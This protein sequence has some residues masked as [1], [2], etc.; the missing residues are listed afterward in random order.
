MLINDFNIAIDNWIMAVKNYRL[1]QLRLQPEENSWSIGQICV[2]LL[3]DTNWFLEQIK[4][5]L[6]NDNR[7]DETV[8]SFANKMFEA[9]SFP[10]EKLTNPSN[11]NM[12]Q[13]TNKE[14]LLQ[15][16]ISLK[17]EMNAVVPQ[18]ENTISDGKTKHPGF[19]YF[20]ATEWLQFATMHLNHH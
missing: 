13:P 2:H 10:N 5:C 7:A 3:N 20:N 1:E 9:N 12:P 16:F 8:I 11:A 19:G 17:K 4:I 18:I 6:V 14:V 15:S